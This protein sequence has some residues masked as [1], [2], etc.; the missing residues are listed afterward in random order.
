MLEGAIATCSEAKKET[1]KGELQSCEPG[2]AAAEQPFLIGLRKLH[3][4]FHMEGDRF[5]EEAKHLFKGCAL[6]CKIQIEADRLPSIISPES[7]AMQD[8]LH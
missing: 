3:N 5:F 2:D 8:T 1:G 7:I 4:S 6:N